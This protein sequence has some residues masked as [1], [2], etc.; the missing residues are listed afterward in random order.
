MEKRTTWRERQAERADAEKTKHIEKNEINFPSLN[1]NSWGE[2][3]K[4]SL[5]DGRKHK[6]F[7]MLAVEWN[8]QEEEEKAQEEIERERRRIEEAEIQEIRRRHGYWFGNAHA[9]E[10]DTYY[11]DVP[12][13][14]EKKVSNEDDWRVIAKKA[15][16]PKPQAI[17][18]PPTPD[19]QC[20]EEDTVW[21]DAYDE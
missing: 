1:A 6:T 15:R 20:V 5:K 14:N 11:D 16:K 3:P 17:F 10:E 2:A 7:A 18:R 21:N 12:E 8:R 9:R 19:E 13:E 4:K